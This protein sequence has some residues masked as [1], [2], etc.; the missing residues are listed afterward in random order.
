[1]KMDIFFILYQTD[2]RDCCESDIPH[3]E[4]SLKNLPTDPLCRN[5]IIINL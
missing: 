3:Y 5:T 1:M 2:L 4:G